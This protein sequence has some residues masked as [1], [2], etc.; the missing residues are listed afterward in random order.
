MRRTAFRLFVDSGR[1]QGLCLAKQSKEETQIY[2]PVAEA[3]EAEL[4]ARQIDVLIVDPFVSSHQVSEN[5]NGAIDAVAKRWGAIAD[6][7]GCAIEIVH[8]L[9]K[10]QG[11]EANAESARGAVSLVAAARSVS[12]WCAGEIRADG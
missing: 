6:R 10:L 12:Q 11:L 5:D 8:H 3:L 4:K 9:R 2:E 1:E 7:A